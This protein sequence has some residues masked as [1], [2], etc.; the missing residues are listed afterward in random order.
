MKP[1][2]DEALERLRLAAALPDFSETR[3][4]QI[5]EL[6]RGGMGVVYLAED[7]ELQR[8]VA[9]KVLHL[10]DVSEELAG[11]M[12]REA[13]TLAQLE[14]PNIVPVYD[15]GRLPDGRLFYVMKHATGQRLDAWAAGAHGLPERLRLFARIAEAT[16]FAHARGVIHRD[17][18][19]QNIM[20]GEFGEVLL[21][22]WG[23]AARKGES[24]Q[25][26]RVMGTPRY[27]APEQERGDPDIDARADIFALGCIL[28]FLTGAECPKPVAAIAAK[29]QASDRGQRYSHAAA[30]ADDVLRYLDGLAVTAHRETAAERLLRFCRR[31]RTLLLLLLAYA[32]A[33]VLILFFARR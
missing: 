5:R 3:Y 16:A 14:H 8:Q 2:S 31:N 20:V 1:L 10:D 22:D 27:M 18:K 30:L 6:G 7:L 32:L 12:R 17:L 13:R 26:G 28:R 9:L 23:L 33:R 21:M 4:R 19:P 29:A 25:P 24:E 15:V 11:R